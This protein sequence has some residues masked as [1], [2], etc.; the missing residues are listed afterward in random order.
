M[1]SAFGATVVSKVNKQYRISLLLTFN[2][3]IEILKNLNI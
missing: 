3:M 1:A 2:I